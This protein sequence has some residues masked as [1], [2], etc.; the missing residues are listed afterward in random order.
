M[1]GHLPRGWRLD[2][3]GITVEKPEDEERWSDE[4]RLWATNPRQHALG[5]E[6]IRFPVGSRSSDPRRS[7]PHLAYRVADIDR[8]ISQATGCEVVIARF[9]IRGFAQVAF[10]R[11]L[12][13]LIELLEYADASGTEWFWSPAR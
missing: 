11:W 7:E 8:A 1:N 6:F 4:R 2:H 12:G 9:E 3:V 5:V 13:V 10:I